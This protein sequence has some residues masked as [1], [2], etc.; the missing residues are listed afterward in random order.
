MYK[1]TL[2]PVLAVR[3]QFTGHGWMSVGTA[4]TVLT[5]G[6]EPTTLRDSPSNFLFFFSAFFV[7]TDEE[8][9]RAAQEPPH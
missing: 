7:Y 8:R 2:V 5:V 9:G 6:P 4:V 1:Q 3:E